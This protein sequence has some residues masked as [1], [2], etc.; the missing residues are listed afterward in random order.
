MANVQLEI[1]KQDTGAIYV[2]TVSSE[3]LLAGLKVI[4]FRKHGFRPEDQLIRSLGGV[5]FRNDDLLSEL[6]HVAHM[7]AQVTRDELEQ[8][9]VRLQLSLGS[10]A[11]VKPAGLRFYVALPGEGKVLCGTQW[12]WATVSTVRDV[13]EKVRCTGQAPRPEEQ[14]LHLL[15]DPACPLKDEA[16]LLS[17]AMKGEVWLVSQ[18]RPAP[19]LLREIRQRFHVEGD[20]QHLG[21]LSTLHGALENSLVKLAEEINSKVSNFVFELLQNADDN[22]YAESVTPKLRFTVGDTYVTSRNNE[23]GFRLEDV[24]AL[25]NVNKST[26][27]ARDDAT[28]EKGLGFKSV[29]KYTSCP[30]V[31]SNSFR[32]K[33]LEKCEEHRLG[34]IIPHEVPA[35]AFPDYDPAETC[36]F[37]PAKDANSPQQKA[38]QKELMNGIVPFVLLFLR[39]LRVIELLQE[40]EHQKTFTHMSRHELGPSEVK[41]HERITVTDIQS[42]AGE[43]QMYQQEYRFL[44]C[45]RQVQIPEAGKLDHR[46]EHCQRTTITLAFPLHRDE[47][48]PCPRQEGQDV[49]AF[50]PV[51]ELGLRFLVQADWILVASREDFDESAWNDRLRDEI[52]ATFMEAVRGH[53]IKQPVSVLAREFF[54]YLHYSQHLE[55]TFLS[56][57]MKNIFSSLRSERCC[58]GER[59]QFLLP[60]QIVLPSANIASLISAER[61][62][63]KLGFDFIDPQIS[64]T[65]HRDVLKA[66]GCQQASLELISPCLD[67]ELCAEVGFQAVLEYLWHSLQDEFHGQMSALRHIAG[68]LCIFPVLRA[69]WHHNSA[70]ES[71]QEN[72]SLSELTYEKPWFFS[73]G[74]DFD[75]ILADMGHNVLRVDFQGEAMLFLKKAG[76]RNIIHEDVINELI[77]PKYQRWQ[78]SWKYETM[79]ADWRFLRL[80]LERHLVKARATVLENSRKCM[81]VDTDWAVGVTSDSS[82]NSAAEG[83]AVR[84]NFAAIGECCIRSPELENLFCG[85]PGAR[86][87]RDIKFISHGFLHPASPSESNDDAKQSWLTLYKDLGASQAL[88]LVDWPEDFHFSL[89]KKPGFG[90]AW[91]LSRRPTSQSSKKYTVV[92]PAFHTSVTEYLESSFTG[93]C[94]DLVCSGLLQ[95]LSKTWGHQYEPHLRIKVKCYHRHRTNGCRHH[96]KT[97]CLAD[98]CCTVEELSVSD[99]DLQHVPFIQ[100][101]RQLQVPTSLGRRCLSETYHRDVQLQEFFDESVPWLQNR[102]GSESMLRACGVSCGETGVN[103]DTFIKWLVQ[104]SH[105]PAPISEDTLV[106]LRETY[107]KLAS[108]TKIPEVARKLREAFQDTRHKFYLCQGSWHSHGSVR[109]DGPL[110]MFEGLFGFLAESHESLRHFFV[111]V[112]KVQA[113]PSSEDYVDA[114]RYVKRTWSERESVEY[115]L[116][117]LYQQISKLIDADQWAAANNFNSLRDDAL[118]LSDTGYWCKACDLIVDDDRTNLRRKLQCSSLAFLAGTNARHI[119]SSIERLLRFAKASFLSEVVQLRLAGE[120]ASRKELV[121]AWSDRLRQLSPA[122]AR[123]MQAKKKYLW[124]EKGNGVDW[125]RWFLLAHTSTV[126]VVPNLSVESVVWNVTSAAE[127]KDVVAMPEHADGAPALLVSDRITLEGE[128]FLETAAPEIAKLYCAPKDWPDLGELVYSLLQR[129]SRSPHDLERTLERVYKLPPMSPE[130]QKMVDCRWHGQTSEEDHRHETL[131]WQQWREEQHSDAEH[132]SSSDWRGRSEA[133][134]RSEAGKQKWNNEDNWHSSCGWQQHSEQWQKWHGTE[135]WNEQAFSHRDWDGDIE[136]KWCDSGGWSTRDQQHDQWKDSQDQ[137][138][139]GAPWHDARDADERWEATRDVWERWHASQGQWEQGEQEQW[140]TGKGDVTERE[141]GHQS[142]RGHDIDHGGSGAFNSSATCASNDAARDAVPS[143]VRAN[144]GSIDSAGQQVEQKHP[145]HAGE[146]PKRLVP[147]P[148][149]VSQEVLQEL[150]MDLQ[151]EEPQAVTPGQVQRA[152]ERSLARRWLDPHDVRELLQRVY[153]EHKGHEILVDDEIRTLTQRWREEEVSNIFYTHHRISKT[154]SH[155]PEQGQSIE[156]L[157]AKLDA[158]LIDPCKDERLR[159]QVVRLNGRVYSLNNRRLWALRTHQEHQVAAGRGKVKVVVVEFDL[160]PVTAKLAMAYTTRNGGESVEF[161]GDAEQDDI[162]RRPGA[163]AAGAEQAERGSVEEATPAQAAEQSQCRAADVAV[164]TQSWSHGRAGEGYLDISAGATVEVL[165]EGCKE[166]ERDWLYGRA[167]GKLGWFPSHAVGR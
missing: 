3:L 35:S 74:S 24:D 163:A 31:S 68:H 146:C 66:L 145:Q 56:R 161:H 107:Q 147:W 70:A 130:M 135:Q 167:D 87:P 86:V 126:Y 119:V 21:D 91:P 96:G 102:L 76:V 104:I 1:Q 118:F 85:W 139:E 58:L 121:E 81:V 52:P 154:F 153:A 77:L 62:N 83:S 59:G 54:A 132:Q 63:N 33:F 30:H 95:L 97:E 47:G 67:A 4:L 45:S 12:S 115:R 71:P 42:S 136:D 125:H 53:F 8:Q 78:P 38:R 127:P 11:E 110:R 36:L 2:M 82:G 156:R 159:L 116:L 72:L 16:S 128:E 142:H 157:V 113:S 43:D 23:K 117:P 10:A 34:Y 61:L 89:E 138:Q 5:A 55:R 98:E 155:G 44:L 51:R 14:T 28:G 19:E 20:M 131:S 18:Y 27:K 39:R 17:E 137:Q 69:T 41:I 133:E 79:W 50:L 160:D 73:T 32:F 144:A 103:V 15:D 148:E 99:A 93:L 123:L 120:S 65:E 6:C 108:M 80:T 7:E 109:W 60:K 111:D 64:L 151:R 84:H 22:H 48:R 101:L 13:K 57:A 92:W 166:D 164:A 122:I 46:R 88:P 149:D 75:S 150:Q 134:T 106:K 114:L 25:C 90:R 158:G 29:F 141:G 165:Y 143:Q 140:Q 129:L 9:P 152:V 100:T 37:L 162:A 40:H 26:K 105:D 94:P 49:F 112:L 124:D